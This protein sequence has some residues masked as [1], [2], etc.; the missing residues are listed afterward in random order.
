M[1]KPSNLLQLAASS[2]LLVLAFGGLEIVP[3]VS[4]QVGAPLFVVGMAMFGV[5]VV[6]LLLAGAFAIGNA[7][8]RP[9]VSAQARPVR[10][11]RRAL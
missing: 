5:A 3:A 2:F 6:S 10:G 7:I 9:F 4:E 1:V 11:L 8:H